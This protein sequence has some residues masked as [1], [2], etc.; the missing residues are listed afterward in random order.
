MKTK[1]LVIGL[2]AVAALVV[3]GLALKTF[4][5]VKSAVK[6]PL[7]DKSAQTSEK[8]P[9]VKKTFSKDMGGLTI[10]VVNAKNKEVALRAKAFKSVNSRSSVY[11]GSLVSNKTRELAPGNYDVELDTVP[12]KIYKDIKISAG[13]ETIENFGCVTGML[14]IKMMNAKN[15]TASYPV[16]VYNTKTNNLIITTMANRPLELLAGTYDIEIGVLPKVLDAAVVIEPGEEKVLNLG[17]MTGTLTVKAVDDKGT[18]KKDAR[19]SVNVRKTGTNEQVLNTKVN[20]SVEIRQGTYIVE[21][22]TVPPQI[23]KDVKIKPGED[24]VVEAVIRTSSQ[25]KPPASAA[26]LSKIALPAKGR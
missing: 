25:A 20:R 2:V 16:S 4:L 1:Y 3:I 12:Q 23:N 6:A 10:Q 22:G 13:E 18:E 26:S 5:P 14:N 15:K 11:A 17:V 8:A 19:Q 7:P 9:A 21:I 24:T